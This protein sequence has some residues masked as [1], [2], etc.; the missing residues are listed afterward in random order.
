VDGIKKILSELGQDETFFSI[1]EYG[2]FAAKKKGG[3]KRVA[4]ARTGRALKS[5]P[6]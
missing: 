1:D 5:C 4:V 3:V 2:P 6:S